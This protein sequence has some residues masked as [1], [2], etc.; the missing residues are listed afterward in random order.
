[1]FRLMRFYSIT[2]F[3]GFVV[4]A[5][6]LIVFVRQLVIGDIVQLAQRSN[7]TLVNSILTT[8]KTDLVEYLAKVQDA[9]PHQPVERQIPARLAAAI[10]ETMRD[11]SVVRVKIYN[12]RGTVVFSTKPE[13]IGDMQEANSGFT[14][15]I[16]GK[17]LSTVIYRDTFN[18]FDQETE[19]DNLMQTYVPA[20]GDATQPISGVLEIYTDI[21]PLVYI[22]ERTEFG[23]L[24]LV[25]LLLSFLYAALI[26][27]MRHATRIIDSQQKTIRDRTAT[28]E[29]L[30]AQMLTSG[31]IEKKRIAF[32]LHEGL[33]Q[34]LSAIKTF[35]ENSREK[36]RNGESNTESLERIVPVLRGAI[37]EIQAI[38]TELRPSSL[39]GLG[40]LAT[41]RWFCRESEQLHP[42]RRIE[43]DLALEENE[44][45]PTLKIVLYRIIE[46]TMK[47]R[48]FY[49]DADRVQLGLRRADRAIVLSIDASPG[50]STYAATTTLAPASDLQLQFA[51]ARERTILSGG[52]FSIGRNAAGGVS[53]QCSWDTA[54]ASASS[55]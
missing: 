46:S 53:L 28:L 7:L 27:I 14:S 39:D 11:G 38:A 17:V 35:I 16:N 22:N 8:V 52:T 33:A 41:I 20:R 10:V 49:T 34:T 47:N 29:M 23:L 1:M 51:E 25:G 12:R 43:H 24:A 6:L 26:L 30:S 19:E 21:T 9:V 32:D 5:V 31:E 55:I 37:S 4:T 44:I 54:A 42:G 36:S 2:S 13:Q 45:P 15:A 3:V 48:V 40:L 18:R 50:D